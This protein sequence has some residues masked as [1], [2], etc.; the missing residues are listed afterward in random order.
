MVI[1][2]SSS[3]KYCIVQELAKMRDKQLYLI[4]IWIPIV[5]ELTLF[6]LFDDWFENVMVQWLAGYK[7]FHINSAE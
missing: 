3:M 5:T 4:F 2:R 6:A 7:T 1:H